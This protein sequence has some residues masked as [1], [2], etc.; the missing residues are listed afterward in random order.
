MSSI[1]K[2]FSIALNHSL[3]FV[4]WYTYHC[5]NIVWT[6]HCVVMSVMKKPFILPLFCVFPLLSSL[7]S[8]QRGCFLWLFTYLTWDRFTNR[9]LLCIFRQVFGMGVGEREMA[10]MWSIF[11]AV[12]RYIQRLGWCVHVVGVINKEGPS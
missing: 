7:F 5:S 4:V 12:L 8:S 2:N 3:I 11:C 9:C 1:C 10:I 6:T